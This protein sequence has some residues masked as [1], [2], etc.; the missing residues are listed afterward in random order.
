MLLMTICTTQTYPTP[1]II[2][3]FFFVI[4]HVSEKRY[5]CVHVYACTGTLEL[6]VGADA[7]TEFDRKAS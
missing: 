7:A 1:D 2:N 4:S 6:R 3:G 5:L